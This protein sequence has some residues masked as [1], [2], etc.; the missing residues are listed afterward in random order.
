[1]SI[2]SLQQDKDI[3]K[4]AKKRKKLEKQKKAFRVL[5]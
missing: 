3:A 1:M 5:G 4:D 2:I